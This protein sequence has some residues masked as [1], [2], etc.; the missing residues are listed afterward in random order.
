MRETREGQ[1]RA[2]E[3][4][5]GGTAVAAVACLSSSLSESR[6]HSGTIEILS[7]QGEGVQTELPPGAA[8]FFFAAVG[9][10]S[11]SPSSLSA[12]DTSSSASAAAPS[13]SPAAAAAAAGSAFLALAFPLAAGALPLAGAFSAGDFGAGLLKMGN[14]A[15]GC[16]AGCGEAAADAGAFTGD[17]STAADVSA[18]EAAA[19]SAAGASVSI[20]LA[21]PVSPDPETPDLRRRLN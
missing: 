19:G 16:A 4:E 12:S 2:V 9:A 17:A 15:T 14:A 7:A 13:S 21:A 5:S 18:A 6:L 3:K 10:A 8:L 20:S 1:V 11:S